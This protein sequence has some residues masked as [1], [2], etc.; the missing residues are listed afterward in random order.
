MQL[1]LTLISECGLK[2]PETL[3]REANKSV[4]VLKF[5]RVFKEGCSVLLSKNP[6]KLDNISLQIT[7]NKKNTIMT[8]SKQ[9]NKMFKNIKLKMKN[10]KLKV[11]L[12]KK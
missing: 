5:D 11:G 10:K 9:N 1:K 6:V 12:P 4:R 3:V 2:Y 8:H 7:I